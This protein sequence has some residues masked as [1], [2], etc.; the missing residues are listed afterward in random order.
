MRRWASKR[1]AGLEAQ[2]GETDS[3]Y[4]S[5]V[6]RP[7][8]SREA[9][10]RALAGFRGDLV[11]PGDADYDAARRLSNLRFDFRP[12]LIAYCVCDS[13]V[14]VCLSLSRSTG[15]P[16]RVRAGGHSSGGYSE[17]DSVI[18]IDVSR[19][20]NV[21][22]DPRAKT[23]TAGSGTLFSKLNA[24]LEHHQSHIPGA[25]CQDVAVGGH[26]QGGG[27]G[28][29]SRTYGMNCDNVVE[30]RVML[31]NGTIVRANQ[32]T[33]YDLWWAVRGGT[34][35]NFGVLL[36]VT[37]KLQQMVSVFGWR[38][39]WRLTTDGERQTAAE[40]LVKMQQS[41]AD[42]RP[43]FNIQVAVLYRRMDMAG[44]AELQLW[45]YGIYVG[46]AEQGIAAIKPIAQLPG[47]TPDLQ[48]EGS[49]LS[50]LDALLHPWPYFPTLV[51]P[52]CGAVASRYISVDDLDRYWTSATW[53]Q[54][55][56]RFQVNAVDQW[57]YLWLEI[58]GAAINAYSLE[59]SAFIHRKV[60]FNLCLNTFWGHMDEPG[61]PTGRR[62]RSIDYMDQWCAHVKP[63]WN[64]HVYQNYPGQPMSGQ[65]YAVAYWGEALPA[66]IEVKKKYDPDRRFDFP[67]AI[68][69]RPLG[70]ASWPP[71]VVQALSQPIVPEMVP[72]IW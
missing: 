15:I 27:Y 45:V 47:A 63:A 24:E 39:F 41:F 4:T 42:A 1:N 13:D 30:V 62:Q 32:Q 38:Y 36:S 52:P 43:E 71:K 2:T 34:G 65:D 48:T 17:S 14:R 54:M 70:A 21:S 5:L 55:L 68:P 22:V 18:V 61:D 53:K 9:V 37:Y 66:L 72:S 51:P 11:F 25:E 6:N 57:F 44:T 3:R 12:A 10:D 46:T 40:A 33:N 19:L 64:Q 16:F 31:A 58:Y 59:D 23:V 35:N 8:I 50:V 69:D 28:L 56:D 7:G 20:D 49:Y 67:Q 26:V 60:A 29:T